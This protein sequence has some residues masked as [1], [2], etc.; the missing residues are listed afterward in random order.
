MSRTIVVSIFF[1][2]FGRVS[3]VN[4]NHNFKS[5]LLRDR[6]QAVIAR[7]AGTAERGT[8]NLVHLSPIVRYRYSIDLRQVEGGFAPCRKGHA[9]CC[10]S[11]GP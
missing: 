5:A 1:S 6:P 11:W 7:W 2:R 4:H 9:D 10:G 3:I 8:T